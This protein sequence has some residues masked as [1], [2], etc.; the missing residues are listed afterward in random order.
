MDSL[1]LGPGPTLVSHDVDEGSRNVVDDAAAYLFEPLAL[2]PHLKLADVFTLLQMNPSLRDIYR[3][4]WSR[5]ICEEADKGPA[6]QE[7]RGDSPQDVVEYLELYRTWSFD[8]STKVYGSVHRLN[9]RGVG[10]E[11]NEDDEQYGAKAG[12]RVHWT[13]SLTPVREVLDL[14]LRL[15]PEFDIEEDDLT[16]ERFGEVVANGV[17]FEL[18]LSQ[19]I[20]A[21]LEEIGF[22][23]GPVQQAEFRRELMKRVDELREGGEGLE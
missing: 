3:R 16:S 10:P 13:L 6:E 15:K 2:H 9:L 1:T 23:G 7:Q 22:H 21:V 11:L 12:E 8:T 18:T 14:P 4:D 20:K 5:E 19:V 17:N